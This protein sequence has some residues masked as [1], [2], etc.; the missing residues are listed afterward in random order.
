MSFKSGVKGEKGI[1]GQRGEKGELAVKGEKGN[2]GLS[3]GDSSYLNQMIKLQN[4]RLDSL[5]Q[6]KGQATKQDLSL[7][8]ILAQLNEMKAF[9]D[10]V[11]TFLEGMANQL[12]KRLN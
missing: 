8:S 2:S 6:I 5:E 10:K 7:K 4:M 3:L 1:P 12:D 11:F 9:D